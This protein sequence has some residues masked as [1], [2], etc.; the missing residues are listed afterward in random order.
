MAFPLFLQKL[1]LRLLQISFVLFKSYQGS[2]LCY[3]KAETT[4]EADRVELCS[5]E[6]VQKCVQYL[7][8][9]PVV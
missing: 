4:L 2:S 7:G 5:W 1:L 9:D 6:I 8:T 3:F